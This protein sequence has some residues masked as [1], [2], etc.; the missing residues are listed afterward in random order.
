[1]ERNPNTD[2][3]FFNNNVVLTL[4]FGHHARSDMIFFVYGLQTGETIRIKN[5]QANLAFLFLM[6]L[7]SYIQVRLGC[8]G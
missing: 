7:L 1:M 5:E 8:A 6:S 2:Y 4:S 3:S